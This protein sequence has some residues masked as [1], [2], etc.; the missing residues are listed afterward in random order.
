MT[1]IP[2]ELERPVESG[3]SCG[4][5]GVGGV[6]GY[7]CIA[8]DNPKT[9]INIGSALRAAGIYGARMVVASG[10]RYSKAPTDT[11]RA[12]RHLPLISVED[13]FSVLPFDCVPV[14][15]E[16]LPRAVA[17]PEYKHPERAFSGGNGGGGSLAAKRGQWRAIINRRGWRKQPP[18]YKSKDLTLV[19]LVVAYALREA[20][21]YLRSTIVWWRKTA[22]EPNRLDRPAV[23][24]E[25]L[26]LLSKS[27]DSSVRDPG[28][29]WWSQS[30]WAIPAS[31]GVDGR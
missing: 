7:C 29:S 15:I 22:N 2:L 27:E 24:H 6:R 28:E 4:L 25:Y 20:G 1:T 16:L 10:C 19:P 12:H 26:F 17:L 3:E 9:D 21:W 18:G 23:S 30:V 11:M 8:L 13:V 5:V 14:A 31:A